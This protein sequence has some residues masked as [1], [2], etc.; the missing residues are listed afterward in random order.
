MSTLCTF[1]GR[2]GDLL[3]A[4]PSVRAIAE[5]L[6]EPVDFAVAGEFRSMLPLLQLQPYIRTAYAIDTW[7]LTPPDEWRAPV[8][9]H[10]TDWDVVIDLGYRGWP[11]KPL[12]YQIAEQAKVTI[13]LS[14]PWIQVDGP[15]IP[16]DVAVGFT[17]TWFELKFGLLMAID[18]LY[19]NPTYIQLTLP[20]TRWTTE[21]TGYASVE[22]VDWLGAARAIRNADLFFGDCSALHVLAVA[23]GKP[24][25]LCEPMEARHNDI[26][27]P[28][29]K[30][31]PQV[32]LIT[33]NDGKP[34]FD[35]RH[36]ADAIRQALYGLTA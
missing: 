2:Y 20:G 1:P 8:D 32:T 13:D 7:G 24:V 11:T 15:G 10:G 31:G 16:L 23:L 19:I 5:R 26:F 25:L 6:G 34:T 21:T 28:L 4:L 17:E 22:V 33:G 18:R 9:L 12:P 36:C 27:Y 29:G 3:W 35:A 14:R 30:T